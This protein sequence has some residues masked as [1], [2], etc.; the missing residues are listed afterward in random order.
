[1]LIHFSAVK[2]AKCDDC[3]IS[4]TIMHMSIR[5]SDRSVNLC[6]ACFKALANA[7]MQASRKLRIGRVGPSGDLLSVER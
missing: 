1:M 5:S 7:L 2:E 4:P 6:V 3:G